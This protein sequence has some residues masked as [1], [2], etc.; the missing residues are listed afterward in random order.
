MTII[1]I[2][3]SYT[4]ANFPP[5]ISADTVFNIRLGQETTFI[6]TVTDPGD[7]FTLTVL[8]GLPSN[9]VL[10][11][12]GE[13]E[14][15]FRWTLQESITEPLIF[16]ANDSKGASAT[17]VPIVEV[18]ACTNG[19]NCTRDGLLSSNATVILNC[20]CPEGKITTKII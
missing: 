5:N 8:G 1:T 2:H 20:I 12:N 9:S 16:S 6:I 17:F 18:C 14:Y 13:G 3:L 11:Y 4:I 7:N 15:I 19:G 10:E